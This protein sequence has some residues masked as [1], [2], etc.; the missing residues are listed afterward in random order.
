MSWPDKDNEEFY[1]G[2]ILGKIKAGYFTLYLKTLYQSFSLLIYAEKIQDEILAVKEKY[3][4]ESSDSSIMELFGEINLFLAKSMA[5]SVSHIH[6]QSEFYVYLK[7]QLRIHDDVKSVTSGLSALDML[8][9]EREQRE[10]DKR[11]KKTQNMLGWL[12]YFVGVPP[13]FVAEVGTIAIIA[14]LS[15]A[16]IAYCVRNVY[17]EAKKEK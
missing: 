15:V 10:E 13:I 6:H 5:T 1:T 7:N 11:D 14:G 17:K 4:T 2:T 9:R 16:V 3:L 8:Q 12:E